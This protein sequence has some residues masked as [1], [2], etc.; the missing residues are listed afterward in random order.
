MIALEGRGVMTLAARSQVLSRADA[1][2]DACAENDTGSPTGRKGSDVTASAQSVS[3]PRNCRNRDATAPEHR[4]ARI[5]AQ[6]SVLPVQE[7]RLGV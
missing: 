6:L 4:S 2:G 1:H 7:F 3:L 5:V